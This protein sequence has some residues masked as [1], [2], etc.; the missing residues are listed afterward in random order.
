MDMETSE[1]FMCSYF[2]VL[3]WFN[4]SSPYLTTT[5]WVYMYMCEYSSYKVQKR[6]LVPLEL[7]L[8][9][10]YEPPNKGAGNW[11]WVFCKDSKH[12]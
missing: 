4:L 7:E 6:T 1:T 11:V 8:T 12:A 3:H 10:S 9:D 5:L 2:E